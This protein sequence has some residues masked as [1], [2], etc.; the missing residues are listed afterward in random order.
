MGPCPHHQMYMVTHQDIRKDQKSFLLSAKGQAIKDN[1]P[2][3]FPAEYI[4]PSYYS[5]CHEMQTLLVMY[6]VTSHGEVFQNRK[7]GGWDKQ[8]K[9]FFQKKLQI[10]FLARQETSNI[11]SSSLET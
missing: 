1:V 8:R 4:N 9:F 3:I 10:T 2:V 7:I 5:T 6:S 11:L